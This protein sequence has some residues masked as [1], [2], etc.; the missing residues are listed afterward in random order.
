M[1]EYASLED[2]FQKHLGDDVTQLLHVIRDVTVTLMDLHEDDLVIG[3]LNQTTVFLTTDVNSTNVCIV[4]CVFLTK[5][6]PLFEFAYTEYN[7]LY[8]LYMLND[9]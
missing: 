5:N 9:E 3:K 7:I 4:F 8:G 6:M 2:C 1:A